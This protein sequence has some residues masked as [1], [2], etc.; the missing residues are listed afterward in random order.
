M[1][2]LAY[3]VGR[4][5]CD[6]A[7]GEINCCLPLTSAKTYAELIEQWGKDIIESLRKQGVYIN[8]GRNDP[9]ERW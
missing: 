9:S 6:I 2:T 3:R 1:T 7:P 8:E 5:A 4:A